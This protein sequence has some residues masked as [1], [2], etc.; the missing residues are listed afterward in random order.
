MRRETLALLLALLLLEA[1]RGV[2]A[3][4]RAP[5]ACE[6]APPRRRKRSR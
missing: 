4:P 1:P 6:V 5:E 2:M 3:P